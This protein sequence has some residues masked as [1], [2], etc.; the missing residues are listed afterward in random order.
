M[1][2]EGALVCGF[3]DEE[4]QVAGLAWSI[5]GEQGA[6]IAC[7]GQVGGPEASIEADGEGAHVSVHAGILRCEAKLTEMTA[8]ELGGEGGAPASAALCSA[9]VS[10]TDQGE[11]IEVG[12]TGH[13]S[14]WRTDPLADA[15]LL[16]HVTAPAMDGTLIL[17]TSLR[18]AGAAEHASE[19]ASAW[20]LDDDGASEF[21]E[22]LL[23]TQYDSTGLAIRAG[24]ELWSMEPGGGATRAAAAQPVRSAGPDA[25]PS[26]AL[27]HT[28]SDGHGGVGG[29]LIARGP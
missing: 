22:A 29:Y 18:P 20:L 12:C 3:S 19:L 6:V 14:R 9:A 27:M 13:L 10:F 7:G 16:R 4:S 1:S 28:S 26:A 25:N 5:G 15:A 2:G 21:G 23:S 11:E 24:L 17:L 8:A